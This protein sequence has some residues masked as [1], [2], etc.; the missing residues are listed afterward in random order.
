MSLTLADLKA[1]WPQYRLT[2]ERMNRDGATFEEI[3]DHVLALDAM[4]DD[5]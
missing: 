4:D 5:D 1:E 2:I 3:E